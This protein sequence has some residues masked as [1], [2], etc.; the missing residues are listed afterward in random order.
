MID[1]CGFCRLLVRIS[2]IARKELPFVCQIIDRLGKKVS[3]RF[4]CGQAQTES[5]V[6]CRKSLCANRRPCCPVL[7]STITVRL[8]YQPSAS[9]IFLSEQTSHQQSANSTFLS[10]R[11]S[12]SHQ[13]PAKRTC[14]L[15]G[16]TGRHDFVFRGNSGK[17]FTILALHSFVHTKT[18]EK[19]YQGL[20]K[21]GLA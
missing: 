12:T 16:S 8:A 14:C 11:T 1:S 4:R 18:R 21:D 3:F 5:H 20:G 17:E 2:L 19:T 10:E 6:N 15:S 13:P 7:L 9:S